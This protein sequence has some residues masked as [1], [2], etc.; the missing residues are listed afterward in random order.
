V[1]LYDFKSAYRRL[2][3][4]ASTAITSAVSIAFNDDKFI[5][6]PLRLPFGGAP[7]PSNFCVV[8]DIITDVINDLMSNPAWDPTLVHSDYV[9]KIPAAR[10]SP[11]NAPFAQA[12]PLSV[13]LPDND[14]ASA[15]CFV[16]DI[17]SLAVDVADNLQRIT[18]APCTVIHALAHSAE[19]DTYIKRNNMIA[20]DKNEAEGAPEESKI[21]LGWILDMR[22]LL[23]ILPNH[24]YIAWLAQTDSLIAQKSAN[25]K[26]LSSLLG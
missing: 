24:K 4:K 19:Q 21:C 25:N 20:D 18:A 15:D 22:R 6:I 23:V 13:K 26:Q 9:H 3:L 11:H 1:S 12:K 2:H 10:M 5:L 7:C 8:S 16:D 17:I 14:D